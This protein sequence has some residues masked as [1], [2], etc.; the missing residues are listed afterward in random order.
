M[1]ADLK[2]QSKAEP[3]DRN[4]TLK[5]QKERP[6]VYTEKDEIK[7]GKDSPFAVKIL[8][9]K[10]DSEDDAF[11]HR[12]GKVEK[13]HTKVSL[14]AG[15]EYRI[16][17]CNDSKHEIAATI[18]IDGLDAFDFFEADKDNPDDRK[19]TSFLVGAGKTRIIKGWKV[20]TKEDKA[21]LVGS[22]GDS[23]AAKRL[24][25]SDSIGTITVC[26]HPAWKDGETP[27]EYEGARDIGTG[28]GRPIPEK[29]KV[30]PRKIGP[31]L[32][33]ISIRYSKPKPESK[34]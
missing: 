27:P 18:T 29:T 15:E 9:A 4:E 6:P 19:P 22:L 25:P 1:N 14:H 10:A 2:K 21:F 34:D 13:G 11:E 20:S 24:K 32:E 30:V 7:V 8:A 23:A 31:L 26:I 12:P 17:L 5:A 3:I 16:E 33:A 28:V